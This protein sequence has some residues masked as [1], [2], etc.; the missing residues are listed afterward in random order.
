MINED[1]SD[2]CTGL[3][4]EFSTDYAF[5]PTTT[6]VYLNGLRQRI[7]THYTEDGD[8][9]GVTFVTAPE[10]GDELVIDYMMDWAT[11]QTYYDSL[12][13]GLADSD[14][15]LL[16]DSDNVLLDDSG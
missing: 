9:M 10:A 11:W 3:E 1:H 7:G 15:V 6:A 5:M 16:A 13:A 4:D 2:E 8:Y 14:N 12:N